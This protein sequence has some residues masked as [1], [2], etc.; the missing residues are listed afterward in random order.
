MTDTL[1]PFRSLLQQTDAIVL[2]HR[3]EART[4]LLES[5]PSFSPFHFIKWGE[6]PVTHMLAYFLDPQ[7]SHGQ[8]GA[9]QDSFIS[10]VQAALPPRSIPQASYDVVAEK[11][12]GGGGFGQI[13]LLL[14]S[15][16]PRFA[17]CI[18][19]KPHSGTVDQVRQLEDYHRF[20]TGKGG[21]GESYLLVYLSDRPRFPA[22]SSLDPTQRETL[23]ATG[24]YLN[25]TYETFLL[26]LL[27][28][29]AALA[30]PEKVRHFLLDFRY[31][32]ERQLHF[33]STAP[34]ATMSQNDLAEL[35]VQDAT[36]LQAAYELPTALQVAEDRLKEHLVAD[37][38]TVA[39]E[40]E[41]PPPAPS[42]GWEAFKNFDYERPCSFTKPHWG[43][44]SIGLEFSGPTL[45]VGVI[46]GGKDSPVGQALMKRLGD[47]QGSQ[48]WACF[49]ELY[50]TDW[51]SLY[52][53]VAAG[54]FLT[55]LRLRMAALHQALD[56]LHQEGRLS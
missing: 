19:N 3:N 30:K 38:L 51:K 4:L 34:T 50:N 27:S 22:P 40:L 35:L 33:P 31:Q 21:F 53:D 11:R 36:L 37:L 10:A 43:P 24:H 32:I 9:F 5:A 44:Y 47:T 46:G 49:A 14:T 16:H 13:D 1:T 2:R 39:A 55:K 28:E 20:L 54:V 25:L 48:G 8:Q 41:L 7:Q 15:S 23:T 18:E 12:H 6:V 17:L 45:I 52:V 56:A 42:D 26:P 29:W